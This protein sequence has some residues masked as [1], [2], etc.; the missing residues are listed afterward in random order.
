VA[1]AAEA[2]SDPFGFEPEEME[3][4]DDDRSSSTSHRR[5][6]HRQSMCF[7]PSCGRGRGSSGEGVAS[8]GLERQQQ[9]EESEDAT[10]RGSGGSSLAYQYRPSCGGVGGTALGLFVEEVD[11]SNLSSS[12]EE[13]SRSSSLVEEQQ[14]ATNANAKA[15]QRIA[16]QGRA[17]QA[18]RQAIWSACVF[19]CAVLCHAML[20]YALLRCFNKPRAS[21]LL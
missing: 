7:R 3:E 4:D 16:R 9:Q 12:S 14:C 8:D 1:A 17:T 21:P 15:T 18:D 11:E 2:E 5:S 10:G 20:Y 19:A 13:R 6:S